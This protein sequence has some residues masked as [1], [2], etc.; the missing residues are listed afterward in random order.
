[1]SKLM[2]FKDNFVYL[3]NAQISVFSL[4][5][6]LYGLIKTK[7]FLKFYKLKFFIVFVLHYYSL[8]LNGI[9]S[10]I[11]YHNVYNASIATEICMFCLM[12]ISFTTSLV[13]TYRYYLKYMYSMITRMHFK[14]VSRLIL[15]LLC[16]KKKNR[17]YYD[18]DT[19]NENED[20][21]N[22]ETPCDQEDDEWF[23]YINYQILGNYLF[24]QVF[25]LFSL[26]V[27][28][29]VRAVAISSNLIPNA[30][31]ALVSLGMLVFCAI[32]CF[33]DCS[34]RRFTKSLILPHL[35]M[36]QLLGT[37]MFEHY[38]NYD[39]RPE[40]LSLITV[41]LIFMYIVVK[42]AFLTDVSYEERLAKRQ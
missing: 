34:Y 7:K 15:P 29:L 33:F 10:M 40:P 13:I 5:F 41:I 24:A 8:I 20:E 35:S 38:T 32:C 22:N 3:N 4:I 16:C 37:W 9:H 31:L 2:Y 26:S 6:L 42:F 36:L 11:L 21:E 28:Y 18:Y 23:R 39:K 1:M 30:Q 19:L 12:L 14:T 17:D 25:V 27:T